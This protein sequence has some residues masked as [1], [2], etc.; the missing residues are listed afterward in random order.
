MCFAERKFAAIYISKTERQHTRLLIYVL[1]S[2]PRKKRRRRVYTTIILTV[3]EIRTHGM[4][5]Y[6]PI[7]LCTYYYI[8][9]VLDRAI[10][11]HAK[12]VK[13]KVH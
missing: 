2:P 4:R 5:Q 11:I 7:V 1:L 13:R 12:V 10:M 3:H 8:I 6:P 9:I